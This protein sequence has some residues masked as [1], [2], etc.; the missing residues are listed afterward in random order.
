MRFTDRGLQALKP[1]AKRYVAWKDN[2]DGLGVRVSPQGRKT[3]VYMFRFDSK[4]RM[5]TLGVYGKGK[6]RLTLAQAQKAHGDALERLEN[7]IDPGAEAVTERQADRTAPTVGDLCA[8]YIERHAKAKKRSWEKDARIL[9]HD[10]LPLWG[11]KKAIDIR[12]RD[13]LALV[14]G[15]ADRGAPIQA[16]RTLACVRKMFSFAMERD[17]IDASPCAGVKAPGKEN[18][19]ER[20]LSPEEIRIV[21]IALETGAANDI[22]LSMDQGTR[23]ALRLMLVTAQRK[24]EVLEAEWADVDLDAALWIIPGAR[25][26]NG[27]SH[28]VPLSPQALDLLRQAKA[29]AG[30]STLIFLVGARVWL[31]GP[32]RLRGQSR[33]LKRRSVLRI[34]HRTICA[35]RQQR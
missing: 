5:L 32:T 1:K 23:I 19:R 2:G 9:G 20:V 10:V 12:R 27:Q 6:D 17:I 4:P 24:A 33:V 18:R 13:V 21:W 29:L 8:E 7:G 3:F 16:N 35:E 30:D 34:G 28:R 15:I 25:A 31:C 22:R 26:K 14:E 11:R